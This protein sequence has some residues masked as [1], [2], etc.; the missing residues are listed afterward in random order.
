MI[1]TYCRNEIP[2]ESYKIFKNDIPEQIECPHCK[3]LN[4]IYLARCRANGSI[5]EQNLKN[6]IK[7]NKG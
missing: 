3:V 5:L 2:S 7:E 4:D 1:C 6:K